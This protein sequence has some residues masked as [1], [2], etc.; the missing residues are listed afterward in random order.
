MLGPPAFGKRNLR[1]VNEPATAPSSIA[2]VSAIRLVVERYVGMLYVSSRSRCAGP[3]RKAREKRPRQGSDVAVKS[4]EIKY[5]W[6]FSPLEEAE[7]APSLAA[8]ITRDGEDERNG[9]HG[10]DWVYNRS[11]PGAN[12]E[13]PAKF[14]GLRSAKVNCECPP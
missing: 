14:P 3:C 7:L 2:R 8:I 11:C 10:G 13:I 6:V 1:Q 12:T 5:F 9:S 4:L